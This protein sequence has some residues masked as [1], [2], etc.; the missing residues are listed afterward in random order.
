MAATTGCRVASHI[1]RLIPYGAPLKVVFNDMLDQPNPSFLEAMAPITDQIIPDAEE[2]ARYTHQQAADGKRFGHFQDDPISEDHLAVI[3][4][5][6]AEDTDPQLYKVANASCYNPDRSSVNPFKLFLWLLVRAMASLQPYLGTVVHRGVKLDLCSDYPQGREFTWQGFT[7][8]TKDLSVLTNDIF[9]GDIG[10]RTIFTIELTQRQARDIS[11][12]SPLSEGEVLL[13]PGSR[14]RVIGAVQQADLSILH[15]LELPSE[16]WISK[17]PQGETQQALGEQLQQ[18]LQG[19]DE[20]RQQLEEERTLSQEHLES[21]M[22]SAHQTQRRLDEA[23]QKLEEEKAAAQQQLAIQLAVQ[24]QLQQARQSLQKLKKQRAA[25]LRELATQP[26]SEW[27]RQLLVESIAYGHYGPPRGIKY[28][29]GSSGD[30]HP[31]LSDSGWST[32]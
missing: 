9:L 2:M 11:T 23:Q 14:F 25:E 10:P 4:K 16:E 7:S 1:P 19:L 27:S 5:Y 22:A 21:Q 32:E 13:P 30:S 18:A 12:Y 28:A 3:L 15:L 24:E 29:K 20:A 8:T 31:S 6:C 26:A 17:L